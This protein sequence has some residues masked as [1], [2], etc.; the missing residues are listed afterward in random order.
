MDRCLSDSSENVDIALSNVSSM[1][2]PDNTEG[3]LVFA[4]NLKAVQA[5]GLIRHN[6]NVSKASV[7]FRQM[8]VVIADRVKRWHVEQ[9]ELIVDSQ[10][11]Y[12]SVAD[13]I[14]WT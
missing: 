5:V 12:S 3:L 4:T 10:L 11:G 7:G 13:E 2:G 9:R 1:R 6:N 8:C 14:R